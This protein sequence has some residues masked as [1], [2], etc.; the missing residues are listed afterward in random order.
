MWHFALASVAAQ[1]SLDA[2]ANVLDAQIVLGEVA[3]VPWVAGAAVEG[4]RISPY[5]GSVRFGTTRTRSTSR[6]IWCG[7]P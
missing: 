1:I 4:Q 3:P 6:G 2:E 5:R 7:G